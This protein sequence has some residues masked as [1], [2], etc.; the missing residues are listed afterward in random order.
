[1]ET[2][3]LRKVGASREELHTLGLLAATRAVEQASSNREESITIGRFA[4]GQPFAN[5]GGKKMAVSISHAAPFAFAAASEKDTYLGVDIEKVRRFPTSTYKSFCTTNE[6]C[7]IES[8]DLKQRDI[9]LTLAWSLKEATLKALG[10]GLRLHPKHIDVSDALFGQGERAIGI[11]GTD[12][13][14]RLFW[15]MLE[16]DTYVATA[17]VIQGVPVLFTIEGSMLLKA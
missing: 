7:L 14:A 9:R 11:E 4:S 16:Q 5:V 3:L 8:S 6:L 15:S 2:S 17:V 1:M 10:T 12:F 13:R